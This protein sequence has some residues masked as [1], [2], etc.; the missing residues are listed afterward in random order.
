MTPTSH[1]QIIFAGD[2]LGFWSDEGGSCLT[3]RENTNNCDP[4]VNSVLTIDTP[5]DS[6]I[7]GR[8]NAL[9]LEP[10]PSKCGQFNVQARVEPDEELSFFRK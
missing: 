1:N 2:V 7:R 5:R 9:V 8:S 10:V 4:E 6:L 3:F